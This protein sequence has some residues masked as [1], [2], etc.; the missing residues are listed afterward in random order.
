MDLPYGYAAEES[1]QQFL[2]EEEESDL[3]LT[4]VLAAIFI[5]MVLMALFESLTL[6]FLVLTS[7]PMALVGVFV[8]FW[9]TGAEFDSS[10]QIGLVLLF[11]SGGEQRDSA[12]QPFSHRDRADPQ[13]PPG[14][15][16]RARR[17][18]LS[19]LA[20]HARR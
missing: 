2:T 12:D 6:P 16:S 13:G 3:L 1:Q 11:R 5:L 20:P 15:R 8:I 9:K 17:G 10:A 19:R 4:T 14:R 7:L 18:D